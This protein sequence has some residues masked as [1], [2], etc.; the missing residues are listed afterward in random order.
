MRIRINILIVKYMVELKCFVIVCVYD[1]CSKSWLVNGK[2][3]LWSLMKGTRVIRQDILLS[4]KGEIWLESV[5][6]CWRT[7]SLSSKLFPN[8]FNLLSLLSKISWNPTIRIKQFSH[9]FVSL[10]LPYKTIP[11]LNLEKLVLGALQLGGR[12]RN[13]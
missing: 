6:N 4:I 9:Q 1:M 7:L 10:E 5:L 2:R 3:R 12:I 11:Q 13:S 8:S